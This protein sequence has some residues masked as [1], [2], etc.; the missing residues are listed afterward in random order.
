MFSKLLLRNA[1]MGDD[2]NLCF[3]NAALQILRNVTLFNEKCR[4]HFNF[5]HIHGD[6]HKILEFEGNDKS[7]SA[8]SLRKKIGEIVKKPELYDGRQNDALEFC[9]YL[10]GNVHPSITGGF[11]F[12]TKTKKRYLIN[13]VPSNCQYCGSAPNDIDD[14][15]LVLKLSFPRSYHLFQ[16]G[17]PL[18]N[19]VNEYFSEIPTD[20][21]NGL[22]CSICC[23]NNTGNES[24]L[25]YKKKP[26]ITQEHIT[27][28]PQYLIIQLL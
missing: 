3:T 11:K 12:K 1:V 21:D 6:L 22:R 23:S 16:N 27:K 15:H 19:M 5:N 24:S 13:N 10:L 18:Q 26:F 8:H 2:K 7:V 17:I 9:E 4:E 28:H 14:E 25:R 20:Q